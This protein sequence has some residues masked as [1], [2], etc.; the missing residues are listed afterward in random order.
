MTT[1][2]DS[3]LLYNF[4]QDVKS[5]GAVCAN[6]TCMGDAEIAHTGRF[7]TDRPY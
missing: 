4:G 6:A 1:P 5:A 7:C 2:Y 3:F